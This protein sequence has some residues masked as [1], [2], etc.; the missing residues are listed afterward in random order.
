MFVIGLL[1]KGIGN[2]LQLIVLL[3]RHEI[4][5][6]L[7][8]YGLVPGIFP[9]YDFIVQLE[10]VRPAAAHGL[11]DDGL[12]VLRAVPKY[13]V[14]LYLPVRCG[15]DFPRLLDAAY[16]ILFNFLLQRPVLLFYAGLEH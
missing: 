16:D 8:I 7:F 12:H 13:H 15:S 14:A 9:F 10:G 2:L 6:D 11:P 3:I 4:G 5:I 1:D